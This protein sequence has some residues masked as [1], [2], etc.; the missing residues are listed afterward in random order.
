MLTNIQ[1][2]DLGDLHAFANMHIPFT[3]GGKTS[4]SLCRIFPKSTTILNFKCIILKGEGGYGDG[5]I[6]CSHLCI[7]LE[8]IIEFSSYIEI[9]FS[10]LIDYNALWLDS[11]ERI[12]CSSTYILSLMLWEWAILKI[13]LLVVGLITRN[14]DE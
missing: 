5:M 9:H 13:G 11:R 10:S 12:V 1:I 4:H 8:W 3:I 6:Y 2:V 7:V 14:Y